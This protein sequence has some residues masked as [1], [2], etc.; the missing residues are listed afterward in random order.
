MNMPVERDQLPVRSETAAV[1]TVIERAA[2]NKDVDIEKLERLLAMQERILARN[3]E[4]AFN[5]AMAQMQSEL[6]TVTQRGQIVVNGQ[7]RSLYAKFEDINEAVKPILQ[8]HGFAVSFKTDTSGGTVKVTGVLTHR[9]GHREQTEMLLPVDVSGSKN[10]VQAVGSSVSYGKRYVLEALLNLTSRGQDD[11]GRTAT[12]N[13]DP[14]GKKA[15]EACG[16]LSALQEAWKKLSKEQ[17]K[18]LQ[19]VKDECKARI[20]SA[21]REAAK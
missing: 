4:S 15:L 3:A 9:E 16:S 18:T 14:E 21:D 1:L 19:A 10:P 20:E 11:D 7:V 2:S 12:T 17:R 8:K 5:S 13:P 6:P